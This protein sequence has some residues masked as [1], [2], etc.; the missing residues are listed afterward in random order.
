[1]K[2]AFPV[3]IILFGLASVGGLSLAK[4]RALKMPL[5]AT[6]A[7][8]SPGINLLMAAMGGFRGIAAEVIWF[9][10]D[11]LQEEGRFV[12]LVQLSDWLTRLDPRATDAWVYNAWNLAYNISVLMRRP[13]DRGRW[14]ARGIRLLRDEGLAANPSDARMYRELG[15]MY[16]NKI[17]SDLDAAHAYYQERLAESMRPLV[18]A[19]GALVDTP[20]ARTALAARRLDFDAMRELETA[21]DDALDWR[22]AEAHAYYWAR[23]ALARAQGRER[24]AARRVCYQALLQ[25]MAKGNDTLRA[26]AKR[27]LD[28][29]FAEN[30]SRT[31]KILRDKLGEEK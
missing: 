22:T 8:S 6:Q 17:G 16:L 28:A 9:R 14:V 5:V 27:E 7:T 12:E 2:R 25:A 20:A 18:N 1:M 13:E 21:C 30:P 23:C 4:L 29:A 11:R 19:H 3:F 26:A 10:M 15:W 24:Q 31:I